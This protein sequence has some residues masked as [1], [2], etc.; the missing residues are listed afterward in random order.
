MTQVFEAENG[1]VDQRAQQQQRHGRSISQSINL[2]GWKKQGQVDRPPDRP[3]NRAQCE[4]IWTSGQPLGRP[5][6][7][8]KSV[9]RPTRE[10]VW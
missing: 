8:H 6:V 7:A 9:G 5:H 2:H 10:L 4:N 1:L 3:T